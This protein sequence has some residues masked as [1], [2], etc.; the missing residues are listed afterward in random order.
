M[1]VADA[2]SATE[3]AVELSS[4]LA[5]SASARSTRTTKTALALWPGCNSRDRPAAKAGGGWRGGFEL[6][7]GRQRELHERAG[8]R[9]GRGERRGEADVVAHLGRGRVREKGHGGGRGGRS[10]FRCAEGGDAGKT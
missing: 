2:R 7:P 1:T 10:M 9:I 4:T 5:V 3:R 6:E 8:H